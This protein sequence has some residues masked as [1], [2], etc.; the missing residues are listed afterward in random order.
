MDT[1]NEQDAERAI[2][3]FASVV[4]YIWT[5]NECIYKSIFGSVGAH[6]EELGSCAKRTAAYLGVGALDIVL[7]GL[8]FFREYA[9]S[10]DMRIMPNTET[11]VLIAALM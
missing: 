3:N 9:D 7:L 4:A 10:L 5:I 11:I 8:S 2:E 6:V 1:D